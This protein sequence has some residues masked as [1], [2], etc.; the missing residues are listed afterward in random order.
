M[1]VLTRRRAGSPDQGHCILVFGL[2]LIGK[3]IL[4]ALRH[5]GLYDG[6]DFAFRWGSPT[7]ADIRPIREFVADRC[8]SGRIDLVW[9]AGNSGFSSPEAEFAREMVS[10]RSVLGLCRDIILGKPN[11]KL[12]FHI[13]SSAGGL[14]EGQTN[15]D[16]RREPVPLRP[17]GR[18]KLMQENELLELAELMQINIYRPS[19]VFGFAGPTARRGLID[20]L[21]FNAA[22]NKVTNIFGSPDTLRDYVFV[23]DIGR[24]IAGRV[25]D[26]KPGGTFLLAS[27]KPSS[28]SEVIHAVEA[29]LNR[30]I[31]RRH[32]TSG[33]N[34]ANMSFNRQALPEDWN[35]TDLV[36]GVRSTR[37][38]VKA[39]AELR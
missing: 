19:S 30:K 33:L 12:S 36:T 3:N 11:A 9:S 8:Q 13:V 14:F 32:D 39:Y 5:T 34:A 6:E 26:G 16:R 37:L 17:Y 24:F 27:G 7:E 15:V 2:G 21:F 10:F 29:A 20:S 38:L 23:K 31:Y 35:P 1:I 28:V 4:A 22:L 25:V 18:V